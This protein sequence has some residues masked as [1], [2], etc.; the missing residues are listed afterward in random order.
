MKTGLFFGSFNPIHIGHL[1]IAN[2]FI[3]FTDLNEIWFVVSPHNPLKPEKSLLDTHLRYKMVKAAV[4]TNK[5][6]RAS[7]ME[8][9]LS[10]PSYTIDTLQHFKSKYPWHDFVVLM[11]SDS[12]AGIKKWKEY[13]KLLNSY[14]VYVY[15]RESHPVREIALWSKVRV[16]DFPFINIS[17]TYIRQ[18]LKEGKSARYLV[19]DKALKY[20]VGEN[21]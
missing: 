21:T 17:A 16:F 1:I 18:L 15:L 12:F 10:K 9:N 11:G 6:F 20:L 4:S 14:P 19:P 7:D 8:F 13:K 3:E 5:R 2:H